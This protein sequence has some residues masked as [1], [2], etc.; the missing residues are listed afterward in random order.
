M[1]ENQ[2]PPPSY[3]GNSIICFSFF[4]S[5]PSLIKTNNPSLRVYSTASNVPSFP[6]QA[7]AYDL[8]TSRT[9]SRVRGRSWSSLQLPVTVTM[10]H[11]KIEIEAP[12]ADHKISCI[13]NRTETSEVCK[14]FISLASV[15]LKVRH[16]FTVHCLLVNVIFNIS[17]RLMTVILLWYGASHLTQFLH[18]DLFSDPDHFI[19][20]RAEVK[21]WVFGTD[22]LHLFRQNLLNRLQAL[23][24]QEPRPVWGR[25]W[26]GV[27]EQRGGRL[28]HELP[29]RP[30]PPPSLHTQ[31]IIPTSGQASLA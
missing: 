17:P 7:E 26:D 28:S 22:I 31:C 10:W 9:R 21:N 5:A 6:F 1:M 20:R 16:L 23:P 18:S 30:P 27:E 3:D 15:C 13:W 12:S 11:N 2:P 29:D 4:F 14:K 24:H 19:W 25:K 8:T